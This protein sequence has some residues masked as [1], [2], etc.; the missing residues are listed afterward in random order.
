MK[1]K[2]LKKNMNDA[3]K[4]TDTKD[5]VSAMKK[6]LPVTFLSYVTLNITVHSDEPPEICIL[7]ILAWWCVA[8]HFVQRLPA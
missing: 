6:D 8:S 3:P 5:N 7:F 2:N 1:K 4:T